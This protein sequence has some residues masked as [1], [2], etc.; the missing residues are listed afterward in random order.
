M[1]LDRPVFWVVEPAFIAAAGVAA[2]AVFFTAHLLE[3]RYRALIWLDA[4]ALA[5]AVPAGVAAA[6][7]AGQPGP[8]SSS[9]AS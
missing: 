9:W 8:S 5:V 2:V 6:M 1:I 3:S 7:F 4:C